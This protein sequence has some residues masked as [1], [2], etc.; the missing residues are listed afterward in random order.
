MLIWPKRIAFVAEAVVRDRVTFARLEEIVDADL[1]A[2]GLATSGARVRL[3]ASVEARAE[4]RRQVER[5]A[6]MSKRLL[7]EEEESL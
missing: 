6:E 1:I 2:M 7:R 4:R 3:R 5:D